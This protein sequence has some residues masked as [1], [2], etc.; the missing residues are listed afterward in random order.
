M[1]DKQNQRTEAEEKILKAAREAFHKKGLHGARM[2]EIADNAEINK[3]MLHY[4]F[5]NKE[6]LYKTIFREDIQA[7]LPR[8]TEFLS[9]DRPLFEKI[10]VFADQYISVMEAQ[11]YLPEFILSELSKSPE[12]FIDMAINQG[13]FKPDK[14]LS[15]VREEMEKGTIKEIEPF[16]L[17]V[18]IVSLCLFPFIARPMLRSL[19]GISDKAYADFIQKRKTEVPEFIIDSIKVN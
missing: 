1:T 3:A 5:R 8:M 6:Q 12:M 19:M 9:E 2:Q 10:R 11:P 13:M 17:L 14:F 15:Q 18:N 16:Q 4:Y 7:F